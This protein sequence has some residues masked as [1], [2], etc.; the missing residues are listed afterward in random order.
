VV[1]IERHGEELFGIEELR[2]ARACS[3]FIARR[4]IDD[5]QAPERL[6]APRHFEE[7]VQV[8]DARGRFFGGAQ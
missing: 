3:A 5:R 4:G 2:E 8:G 1:R 6:C 7:A